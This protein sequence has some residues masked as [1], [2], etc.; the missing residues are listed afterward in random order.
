MS[1]FIETLFAQLQRGAGRVV[2][3]EVRGD[4]F[5][6]MTGGELLGQI[7]RARVYLRRFGLQVGDR[8]A[9]VGANSI[10]WVIIDLALTAESV[11]VV[12]LYSRQ[13]PAELEAMMK[14]CQPRL[15]IADDA[16]L[17]KSLED[18]LPSGTSSVSFDEVLEGVAAVT[19][20]EP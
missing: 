10:R 14:D 8:C 11:I 2:L 9:I 3:R 5:V 18:R 13:A 17:Q 1:N 7:R 6:S 4:Q 15:L 12:P 20:V 16:Q 19:N